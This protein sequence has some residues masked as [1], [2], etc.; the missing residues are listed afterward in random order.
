MIK[1]MISISRIY[2]ELIKAM[3]TQG[4]QVNLKIIS[5]TVLCK[6]QSIYIKYWLKH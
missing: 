6:A 3:G 4:M 5:V 1:V 2:N